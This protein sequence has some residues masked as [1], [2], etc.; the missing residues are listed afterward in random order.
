MEQYGLDPALYQ[1]IVDG[2]LSGYKNYLNERL[3]KKKS[4]AVSGA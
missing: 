2:T 4:M 1:V 3:E